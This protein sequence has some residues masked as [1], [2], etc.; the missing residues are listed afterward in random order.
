VDGL[1]L[2]GQVDFPHATGAE[3]LEETI[4]TDHGVDEVGRGT[5]GTRVKRARV[6]GEQAE[7]FGDESIIAA[8][9]SSQKGFSLRLGPSGGLVKEIGDLV[10]AFPVHFLCS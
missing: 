1:F 5:L 2:F 3:Q 6:M 9:L 10:V 7:Y 8:T 4:F